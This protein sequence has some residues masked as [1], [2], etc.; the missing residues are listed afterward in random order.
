MLVGLGRSPVGV[1]SHLGIYRPSALTTRWPP[2]QRWGGADELVPLLGK[3]RA[4]SYSAPSGTT[5]R[6]LALEC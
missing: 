3:E 4:R 6:L 1:V 2:P 5:P